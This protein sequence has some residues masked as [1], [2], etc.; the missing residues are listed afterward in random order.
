VRREQPEWIRDGILKMVRE[1]GV[2]EAK[3]E[4]RADALIA[5]VKSVT[6]W[7]RAV[8]RRKPDG[9]ASVDFTAGSSSDAKELDRLVRRIA[10]K[11]G[12]RPPRSTTIEDPDQLREPIREMRRLPM[13]I[14][15]SSV[16]RYS[17]IT[18]AM[19]RAF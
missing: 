1:D 6:V 11:A 8:D 17:G 12:G 19:I 15:Q 4:V 14:T 5:G 9:T 10:G 18:R 3:I 7:S 16:E 2:P 13:R